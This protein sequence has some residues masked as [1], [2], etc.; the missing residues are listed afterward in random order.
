[1]GFNDLTQRF[2]STLI[3]F[4]SPL[5]KLPGTTQFI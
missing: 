3:G 1:M 5:F 2:T 4:L